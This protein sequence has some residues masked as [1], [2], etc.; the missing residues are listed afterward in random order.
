M[1]P[2][3]AKFKLLIN[4]RHTHE[5]QSSRRCN[6][7][8][9]K[10]QREAREPTSADQNSNYEQQLNNNNDDNTEANDNTN[11]SDDNDNNSINDTN[12]AA[13]DMNYF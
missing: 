9:G 2:R 11:D 13:C 5:Y 7:R 10:R 8:N 12:D 3:Q 6:V 4:D 1:L